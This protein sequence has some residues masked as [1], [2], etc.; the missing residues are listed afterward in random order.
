MH[1]PSCQ[2]HSQVK[3]YNT[4]LHE[5]G[6][7][8]GILG[9]SSDKKD[10]MYAISKS[11][12]KKR[13]LSKKDIN[14]LK[15]LYRLDPD[16]SNFDNTSQ[17]SQKSN[18]NTIIL[19]NEKKQKEQKLKEAKEYVKIASSH[20]IS[21]TSLGKAY[22]DLKNYSK[23]LSSYKKA[24]D[25]DP[26]YKQAIEGLAYVYNNRGD[27]V[28]AIIHYQKLNN[29]EPKNIKFALLLSRLYIEKSQYQN[30]KNTINRLIQYNPDAS[31]NIEVKSIIDTLSLKI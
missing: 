29:L 18:K 7:V 1:L 28:N 14:T 26:N 4:C 20:P 11:D 25:L 12:T 6:H 9:H 19:G 16:V 27:K 21:W 24:L 5:I 13:T 3:V 2:K 8:L 15:L 30:A 23:A 10:I 17:A 31:G 22:L